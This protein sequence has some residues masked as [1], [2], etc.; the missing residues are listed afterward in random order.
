MD[1]PPASRLIN[2]TDADPGETAEWLDALEAVLQA[3]GR[4]RARFLLSKL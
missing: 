2:E 3:G 1:M 4:E